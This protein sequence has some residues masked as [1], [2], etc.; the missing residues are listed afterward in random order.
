MS[1]MLPLII[2]RPTL[3]SSTSTPFGTSCPWIIRFR[4]RT[5]AGGVQNFA[6]GDVAFGIGGTS[7]H[8]PAREDRGLLD[9]IWQSNPLLRQYLGSIDNPQFILESVATEIKPMKLD[10]ALFK[11]PPDA[12]L[13]KSPY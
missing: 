10:D 8:S 9:E 7:Q 11:L 5:L 3:C 4:F 12:K 2:R 1:R 6:E 13:E